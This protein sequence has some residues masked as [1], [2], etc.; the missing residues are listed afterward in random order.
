MPSIVWMPEEKIGSDTFLQNGVVDGVIR[1]RYVRDV[2]LNTSLLLEADKKEHEN[3]FLFFHPEGPGVK[4]IALRVQWRPFSSQ[5][6]GTRDETLQY[7]ERHLQEN[8]SDFRRV[9]RGRKPYQS[10]KVWDVEKA[11]IHLDVLCREEELMAKEMGHISGSEDAV[12]SIM[13]SGVFLDQS[14]YELQ[15]L[16]EMEELPEEEFIDWEKLGEE[17]SWGR[18]APVRS[19]TEMSDYQRNMLLAYKER[20]F[21]RL[22]EGLEYFLKTLY[23]LDHPYALVKD[24]RGIGKGHGLIDFIDHLSEDTKATLDTEFAPYSVVK[25]K[26]KIGGTEGFIYLYKQPF[27]QT[28]YPMEKSNEMRPVEV[29]EAGC[30]EDWGNP[31]GILRDMARFLRYFVECRKRGVWHRP[32]GDDAN[33]LLDVV[34]W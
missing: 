13:R 30:I 27:V 7:A 28:R 6:F 17:F 32:E 14:S 12:S 5:S 31:R 8:Y 2:P 9:R 20:E 26:E 34:I 29:S 23:Y 25:G 19:D 22:S 16:V 15:Q 21:H 18:F 4:G 11:I 33:H 1:Y 24:V 10:P 3:H